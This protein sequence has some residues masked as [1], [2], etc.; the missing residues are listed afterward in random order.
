MLVDVHCHIGFPQFDQ[1]RDAV[2]Q[3]AKDSKVVA[4]LESGTEYDSNIRTLELAKKYDIIKPSLGIY[5]TYAEK[6]S[7]Q[8]FARDLK[9]IKDNKEKILAIGEV[10]LDY[11]H[12]T[13][14]QLKKIQQDRFHTLLEQLGKLKKPFVVHTRKAEKDVIDILESKAVK[15]VDFHCFTG[16]YKLV[17]RVIDN[18]WHFSIP[19]NILQTQHFQGVVNLAPFSQL[20]TETD[21][22]Y[23]SPPNEQRNEPS[24][25]KFTVKKI[26][27]IKKVDEHE[28]EN[29]IFMNYQKLFLSPQ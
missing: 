8:E 21:S 6:L 11:H 25:V 1:D 27:E 9:F 29:I 2:I 22:P 24:F 20:L 18:G 16:N 28:A 10:G 14:E 5:P 4:I 12:T 13:D 3:R 19:P 17:K 15:K 23:L 7:E 26:A